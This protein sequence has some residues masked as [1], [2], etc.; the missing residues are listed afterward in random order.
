MRIFAGLC[1]VLWATS[2]SAQSNFVTIGTGS[3]T[4]VYFP[5]GG[6]ICRVLN[7]QRDMHGYRCVVDPTGG[8]IDNLD[9]LRDGFIDI[10]VVQADVQFDAVMGENAFKAEPMPDLRT[11]F[12]VHAEA[13]TLLVRNDSGIESFADLA[14]KRVNIGNPGSGNRATMA[15]M[16]EAFS[17][18]PDDF[19]EATEYGGDAML[20]AMCEN[21][22]DA[23]V[24]TIGHPSALIK[25]LTGFCDTSILPVDSDEVI[26]MELSH[27]F[28]QGVT[29]PG[30]MYASNAENIAT[31]GVG[32]T[33]VT[34][35]DADEALIYTVTKAVFENLAEMRSLH[36]AFANLIA[37]EMAA[38]NVS[39]PFHP[40]AERALREL[41][42]FDTSD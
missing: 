23:A 1:L 20:E 19:A 10:G 15:L 39:A 33:V 7:K 5:T 41:R 37:E 13:F 12:S 35:A 29:I 18:T 17:L 24:Y 38:G 9:G 11:M 34:M 25:E 32:A 2:L 36:P 28:Y 30:G 31:I 6:A 40:G 8:S 21:Q 22:L 16:M 14:G 3:I 4:G 42:L 27:P 26:A